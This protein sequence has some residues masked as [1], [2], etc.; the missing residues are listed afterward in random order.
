MNRTDTPFSRRAAFTL[1]ELLV[2]M[3]II[4]ILIGLL[5]P[6][7]QSTRETARR[8][9]C[10]NNLIQLILAVNNYEMAHGVYPPGTIAAKGPVLSTPNGFHHS[11]I[12][13]ILPYIEHRNLYDHLDHSVSAYDPINKPVRELG[14]T[15]VRCPSTSLGGKGY[16]DYA[17]VHHDIEAPID[18]NNNGIFFLNSRVNYLDVTD[19]TA[20]TFFIGEKLTTDG[21]LGWLSG[22]R[23]TL[24]N[25]GTP[26][27]A[28]LALGGGR[29][30]LSAPSGPPGG[31]PSSP[32]DADVESSI[33]NGAPSG[34]AAVGGFASH[35][36]GGANF[37]RGDGS[38]TFVSQSIST[39]IYQQLGHRADGALLDLE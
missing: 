28:I 36:P 21:D 12:A 27:N 26:L 31:R 34:P 2:V 17:G 19:G 20:Q 37:A 38:I 7:V 11:W 10:Q 15:V 9:Q 13:Q 1:V 18:A 23:A 3:A 29:R 39:T 25:T 35:H 32:P 5:L 4:G 22:T 33:V 16:S 6:A 24:R 8:M 30:S 14:M